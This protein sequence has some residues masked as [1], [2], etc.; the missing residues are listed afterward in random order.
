MQLMTKAIEKAMPSLRSTEEKS[1]EETKVIVKFF[2]PDAQ[3]S[4]FVFEGNKT[5]SGDWEF[6]GYVKGMFGELGYFMLSQL[7]EVRG[8]LGLPVER[9]RYFEGTF[10]DIK[11]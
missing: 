4:W 9:D 5:E 2:T 11:D 1:E 3:L 8:G 7:Q 6:F 10:A